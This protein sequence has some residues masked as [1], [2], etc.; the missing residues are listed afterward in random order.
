MQVRLNIQIDVTHT[1][2]CIAVVPLL[3]V[4][5]HSVVLRYFI[6]TSHPATRRHVYALVHHY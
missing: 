2:L 6:T 4:I 5:A 1:P 3:T